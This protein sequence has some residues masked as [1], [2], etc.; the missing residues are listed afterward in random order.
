MGCGDQAAQELN[1]ALVGYLRH[2]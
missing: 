1:Q 2:R